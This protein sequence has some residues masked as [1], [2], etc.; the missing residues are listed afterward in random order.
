MKKI[1]LLLSF[2]I[3]FTSLALSQSNVLV[4]DY[5]NNFSSDQS[6]NAS[7]IYNRLLATQT[8]VLRVNTIPATINPATYDQ[9]WIFGNMGTP[10]P[11]LL[12]PIITYMNNG[13][14][15]YI[16]SEVSCCNNPAAFADQ[17]IDATTTAGGSI[18]HNMTKTGN[19][20][21]NSYSNL[22]C[23]PTISHGAAVRPFVGTPQRNILYE[24]TNV[25]GG[26]ITTGDVVG[27]RFCAGDMISGQGALIVNGDFNIFPLSGTC[28][29][30]G[31]LGTPNNNAVI[32]LISDL[33]PA[34]ACNGSGT[35]STLTLT[36]NPV[37]FCGSTQLGWFF[38]PGTGGCG[39]IGCNTDTTFKWTSIAGD[40]II[41]GGNF[42]CDTCA[43]PTA[44][45]TVPTTYSLTMTIGDSNACNGSY[46]TLIPITVFPMM[47]P[48][49]DAGT[50]DT[51]CFGQSMTIGGNPTGAGGS[52]GPYTYSWTPTT[53][54]SNPT[55]AN[56][57]VTPT[58]LGTVTYTVQVSES[59][60]C[61]PGFSSVNITAI[62]CCVVSITNTSTTSTS[63]NS[64]CDGSVTIT[65]NG[66]ATQYSVDG[67]NWTAS[68]TINGLCAGNYSVYATGGTCIDSTTIT[69]NE[70]TAITIPSTITDVTCNGG[71]DGQIVVAPQG[72]AGGYNY[73]WSVSGI[74][75][76]P[77]ATN[78]SAG[79]V[80]VTVTDANG[81]SNA[82]TL[83]V[84]EP[85][86]QN[87]ITF[88][89]SKLSG[90]SP[91]DVEFYN[92]TDTNLT[93]SIL[94][95]IGNGSALTVDTV[96]NTYTTP[97]TYDVTLSIIDT[98][99]CES[100]LKK[101][102]YITVFEDPIANFSSSPNKV[103]LFDPIM[104]FNDLS[105]ANIIS[106][107][108]NFDGL[109]TSNVQHPN[110]TFPGDDTA[111]YLIVLIVENNDGCKDTTRKYVKIEGE[112]G[113]FVPTAFTPDDDNLNET[114]AP[115]GFGINKDAYSF[116]IFNRWGELIFKSHDLDKGWNGT[117][118]GKL[119]ETGSYAWRLEFKDVSGK[120]QQYT[121][122]VSIIK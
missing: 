7:N 100:S 10:T 20:Q 108:W 65:A 119:V 17:L 102:A 50:D 110:F 14:A 59:G 2:V 45:P 105:Q 9:V 67:I 85:A 74:G 101:T 49:A 46:N 47:P 76:S 64:Q 91:L 69:I 1:N 115:K 4:I 58:V 98:T 95:N 6:N 26:T 93:T 54:L 104:Y 79:Q 36:A 29:S 31:I 19:F 24:A 62:S 25:C 5:N 27:V 44:W 53:G 28:G 120:E 97:G 48:L 34:L 81:C 33:L 84:G 94:W 61:P 38:T 15:V 71:S 32:D 12:N 21:Y 37:N 116:M 96:S 23:S 52:G 90:C 89:A 87:F 118:K 60:G 82:V 109:G 83:T 99:G 86:P 75:N 68:N 30:V 88:E 70:P 41:I 35:P 80:T 56:P 16:Q 92:T 13:G 8:S 3:V 43:Y 40:P 103:T 73:S 42:S 66:G 113:I 57:V 11:A 107:D 114:F 117:Y 51:L 121:G 39:I 111:S 122:K 22:L 63:C 72:G 106:W 112:Y 78:L 77:N 55:I 18:S